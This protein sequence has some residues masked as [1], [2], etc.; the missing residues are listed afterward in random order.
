MKGY[1]PVLFAISAFILFQCTDAK[2]LKK[3]RSV[4]HGLALY[5]QLCVQCHGEDG[6]GLGTLYPPLAGSDYIRKNPDSLACIIKYGK[7]GPLEVNGV[8]YNQP[9]PGNPLLLDDEV[10][11]L[12]NY[13]QNAWGN[14]G[15][16]IPID[17]ISASIQN[18]R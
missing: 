2:K 10:A 5:T 7:D 13:I 1:R 8:L 16:Y 9:M 14:E 17:S 18:C 15:E 6:K 4:S 3:D 12:V 11:H